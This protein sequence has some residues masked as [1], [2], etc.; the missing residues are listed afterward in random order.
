MEYVQGIR[1][2][3]SDTFLTLPLI[4][5]GFMFFLGALTSNSGLLYLF[6]GHLFVVPSLEFFTNETGPAWFEEGKFSIAK[7]VKWIIS[8]LVV[9]TVNIKGQDISGFY[10][11]LI[12]IPLIGQFIVR[13]DVAPVFFTNPIAW[14]TKF[15]PLETMST[16]CAMV[17]GL[18]EGAKIY[19]SPSSWTSHIVF[20][21]GF[22]F[23]NA[24]AIYNQPAP[25]VKD[26]TPEQQDSLTTRVANRKMFTI[27]AMCAA[28]FMLCILLVFRYMKTGCEYSF[29]YNL[30]PL[31]LVG[32]TGASWFQ[33]LLQWCGIRPADI[34]GIVQGMI[35]PNSVDRP[36]VCVAS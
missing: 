32:L 5:I 17:P 36:I 24:L 6:A 25:T 23:A 10:Y 29:L 26:G 19:N 35:S 22:F 15:H 31:A 33:I 3:V 30:F 11:F 14:F 8:S 13:R 27:W 20:F 1:S 2:V 18:E 16:S 7:L 12:L 28:A 21:F 4:L 9:L 34:L